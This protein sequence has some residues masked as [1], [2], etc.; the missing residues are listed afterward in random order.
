MTIEN[1]IMRKILSV[2]DP[3]PAPSVES[4]CC[5]SADSS[6]NFALADDD[7]DA[8]YIRAARKSSLARWFARHAPRPMGQMPIPKASA[9]DK[10]RVVMLVDEI[11]EIKTADPDADTGHLDWQIDDMVYHLYGLTEEEDT[12]VERKLGL[13]HQTDEEEDAAFLKML[14]RDAATGDDSEFVSEEEVM[15]VLRGADDN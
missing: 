6:G 7:M 9:A 2:E 13:I 1:E 5:A 15:A 11:L 14:E 10:K 12:Y 8:K 3:Q 4:V